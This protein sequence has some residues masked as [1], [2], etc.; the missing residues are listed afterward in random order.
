MR[1]FARGDPTEKIRWRRGLTS[2][3]TMTLIPCEMREEKN[4]FLLLNE[5]VSEYY[6]VYR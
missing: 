3:P 6:I 2:E 4:A 5:L 1:R